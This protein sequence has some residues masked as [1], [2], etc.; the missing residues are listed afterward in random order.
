MVCDSVDF[1]CACVGLVEWGMRNWKG[2]VCSMY[3]RGFDGNET[4]REMLF[5][6]VKEE[7]GE[8]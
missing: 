4:G 8:R 3:G 6:Y 1:V 7:K 2:N 5:V